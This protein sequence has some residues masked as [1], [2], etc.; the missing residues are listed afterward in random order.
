MKNNQIYNVHNSNFLS[1][2]LA[3]ILITKFI[4]TSFN[5]DKKE[6]ICI[7]N[8]KRQACH[9][10]AYKSV[11]NKGRQQKVWATDKKVVLLPPKTQGH[12]IYCG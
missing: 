12:E 8:P 4:L 2:F 11:P 3:P 5:Q 1:L 6:R 10:M 9:F 7:K